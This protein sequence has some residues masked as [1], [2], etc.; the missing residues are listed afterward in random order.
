M[1]Q[2]G[3]VVA[4]TEVMLLREQTVHLTLAVAAVAAVGMIRL[5]LRVTQA[6]RVVPVSSLFVI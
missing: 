3:L 2:E 4:V 1:E 6:V 5:Y